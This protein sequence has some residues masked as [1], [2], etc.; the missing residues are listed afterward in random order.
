VLLSRKCHAENEE[1]RKTR[2]KYTF[3]RTL[4]GNAIIIASC[5]GIVIHEVNPSEHKYT[6]LSDLAVGVA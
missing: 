2:R 5:S 4:F 6:E 3:V 1:M